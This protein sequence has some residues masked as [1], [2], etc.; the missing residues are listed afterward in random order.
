MTTQGNSFPEIAFSRL[1]R[2]VV[3]DAAASAEATA[4][5]P[6]ARE[7]GDPAAPL[8]RVRSR[9]VRVVGRVSPAVVRPASSANVARR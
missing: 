6:A 7:V 3:A 5:V 8:V 1:A 9:V 4:A 2:V